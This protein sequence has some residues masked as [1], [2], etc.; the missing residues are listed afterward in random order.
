MKERGQAYARSVF[1]ELVNSKRRQAD[2]GKDVGV[3]QSQV[4]KIAQHGKTTT[5]VAIRAAHLAGRPQEEIDRELGLVSRGRLRDGADPADPK[6]GTLL[7]GLLKTPGLQNWCTDHPGAVTVSQVVRAIRA[8]ET[9]PPLSLDRNGGPVDGWASF[10]AAMDAGQI[11]E[12][13]STPGTPL[14]A[15]ELERVEHP[16]LPPTHAV[17]SL[18]PAPKP[19]QSKKK[20]KPKRG[21]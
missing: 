12:P 6:I 8:F 15:E 19:H 9:T 13:T 14:E 18:P 20:S 4:S 10:F 21:T 17:K 11:E 2:I 16:D 3:D 7:I 5:E 1:T